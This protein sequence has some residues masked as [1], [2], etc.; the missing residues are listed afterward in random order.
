MYGWVLSLTSQSMP[1]HH[2]CPQIVAKSDILPHICTH[3]PTYVQTRHR[4]PEHSPAQMSNGQ[5]GQTRANQDISLPRH[6][7]TCPIRDPG[8]VKRRSVGGS[9]SPQIST[10]NACEPGHTTS[11]QPSRTKGSRCVTQIT[12][13]DLSLKSQKT[14]I[15]ILGYIVKHREDELIPRMTVSRSG[16]LKGP[17]LLLHQV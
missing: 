12:P 6:V 9:E 14:G 10:I 13:Q 16:P 15:Y 11:P 7:R 5:T 3:A 17:G 1:M 8:V 4:P 2:I